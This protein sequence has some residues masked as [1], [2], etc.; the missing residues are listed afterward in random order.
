MKKVLVF[1]HQNPD[2]DAISSAISYAYLLNQI[3]VAAEPVALGESNAETNY[4]LEHFHHTKL[5]VVNKASEETDTVALVDHNEFQQSISDIQEVT[6]YSVVDHHKVGNFETAAPLYYVAKPYGCTQSVIYGLYKEHGL[7][8][9]KDIAGLML[10]G[11]ISDTLLYSSPTCTD[12]DVAIAKE[13]AKIADVNDE[14]YGHEMLRAG[15]NVDDRTTES[16]VDGDAKS[17]TI[18]GKEIRVGQVNCVDVK[19]VLKRKEDVLKTMENFNQ[20]NHYDA[21]FLV[22]T[23]ILTND[24]EGLLI[25]D[26]ALAGF[27]EK[28]FNST[29]SD[30]QMALPGIV[31]RKKQ[32]IPPLTAA[33]EG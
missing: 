13:L 22:I 9:P 31:S 7:A 23:N 32:I 19:D 29:L 6:V 14:E 3:G 20:E 2:T 28:A 8:I 18:A 17:F 27:F 30:H 1:G 16:I 12:Q 24:S 33:F 10:S 4:A 5:R 11:I 15:A 21:F 26:D 25:G